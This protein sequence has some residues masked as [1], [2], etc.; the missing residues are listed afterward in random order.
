MPGAGPVRRMR[1]SPGYA[2]AAKM[3][4]GEQAGVLRRAESRT[5][6]AIRFMR[7]VLGKDWT[8]RQMI[9]VVHTLRMM[10]KLNV[11]E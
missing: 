5:V 10:Q 4:A 6:H 7:Q 2:L 11:W 9:D 8:M 1:E 3:L